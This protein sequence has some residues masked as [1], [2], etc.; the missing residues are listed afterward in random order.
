MPLSIAEG[1][2]RYFVYKSGKEIMS[3]HRTALFAAVARKLGFELTTDTPDLVEFGSLSLSEEEPRTEPAAPSPRRRPATAL[4]WRH[5]SI[6][7]GATMPGRKRS[8]P[9]QVACAPSRFSGRE[10]CRGARAESDRAL[11]QPESS[12]RCKGLRPFYRVGIAHTGRED[13][14]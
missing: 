14:P 5:V 6:V 9:V 12:Y 1:A 4:R 2:V 7:T 13:L 10:E 3:D 11:R 8:A